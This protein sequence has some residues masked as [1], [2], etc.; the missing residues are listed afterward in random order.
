MSPPVPRAP[1]P[2]ASG[3]NADAR[4]DSTVVACPLRC[5]NVEME[6]NNTATTTD[7]LVAV[8]CIIPAG[9]ATTPCRIRA[10][11]GSPT[12]YTV[13]LTNPDHRLRFPGDAD[14]TLT[15]SLPTDNSW[16][17]FD[18]SGAKGSDA[19]NDAVIEVHCGTAAGTLL[20]KKPV[21]VF[22]FDDAHIDVKA[23]GSYSIAPLDMRYDVLGLADKAFA[24][25]HEA[26]ARIRPA[27]VN[28]GAPQ[29]RDLR[30]G[31]V[32]NSFPPDK[33]TPRLRRVVYGPPTIDWLPD[34]KSGVAVTIPAEWQRS[35]T[36]NQ[37]HNDTSPDSAPFYGVPKG[38]VNK[39]PAG[40]SG[41]GV[42]K[43]RDS[44]STPLHGSLHVS[45]TDGS[46]HGPDRAQIQDDFGLDL[47]P[48]PVLNGPGT[49]IGTAVYPFK[50]A[51]HKD[52][53]ITWVVIF[54]EKTKDFCCLRQRGW[55]LDLDSD[56][57]DPGHTR[58]VPDAADASP[59]DTPVTSGAL[60]ND[61]TNDPANWSMGPMPGATARFVS[62]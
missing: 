11:G 27:G 10:H 29:I 2:P 20:A 1:T 47:G 42:T 56:L 31:I 38:E 41:S 17:S 8:K 19:L 44:P 34:A 36:I 7:D 9:A 45:V 5:P 21:T 46:G 32:Q 15:L 48:A 62:P 58:A 33:T 37:I 54:N 12:T 35:L 13:V 43:S 24:V 26:R 57:K 14:T 50:R 3:S 4:C 25:F 23:G 28:C 52:K 40:C 22:W 60:S 55:T 61:L 49:V 16:A 39:R 30:V 6:I 51:T 59:S 53:F 18:I